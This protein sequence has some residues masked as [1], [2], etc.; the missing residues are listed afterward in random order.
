M[1]RPL[2]RSLILALTA[3]LALAGCSRA[4][5][6][7]DSGAAPAAGGTAAE[8]RLGYFPNVTHAAAIIGDKEGLFA[9]ELGDT[10]LTVQNFNAGGEAVNALFGGSIDAT[11][12]GS[13]P[14]INAFAQ[15]DGAAVRLVAGATDGGA[16]LVVR[17]DITSPEQLRGATIATPQLG[18][19][20]DIALKVWLEEQGLTV[21]AN[22][23][24]V[25]IANLEN[26]RTLDAFRAGEVDGAWLPEPWSSRLVLDAG[27]SVLL[28]ERE[29]WE[30]G[31]FP[32]TVLLVST[33]FLQSYPD[34]VRAL[35]RGHIAATELATTDP[36]RAKAIVNDGIEEITGN[37]LADPVIE[38]AFS[39]LAFSTDPLAATFPQLAQDSLDAG[40]T[41]T[42]TDL[43]GFVDVAPLN[44]ELEAAGQPPVDAA[45]LDTP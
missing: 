25:Q 35:I 15:S 37:R 5:P 17:P 6:A 11:F 28:D 29:L 34:T 38:R 3:A 19:T 20:Q 7:P 30:G 44:A 12:I 41:D 32:T 33:E 36:T 40:I 2:T 42:L 27:A 26:P 14:A 21:G 31:Q 13:G 23:D 45:G 8:L 22:P 4:E 10:A 39:E 43:S 16:Q 1:A 24:Q 9:N 18:N